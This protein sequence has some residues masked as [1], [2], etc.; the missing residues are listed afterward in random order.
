[1]KFKTDIIA[2]PF[3]AFM[4]SLNFESMDFLGL[5]IDFLMTKITILLLL[6]MAFLIPDKMFSVKRVKYFLFPI[7]LFLILLTAISFLHR[8]G[9]TVSFIDV[10]FILNILIFIIVLNIGFESD[11]IIYKGLLSF[12]LGATIIAVLGILNIQIEE[13][14]EGRYT[15]FGSNA[16][17]LGIRAALSIVIFLF[18]YFKKGFSTLIEKPVLLILCPLMLHSILSTGSRTAFLVLFTGLLILYKPQKGMSV[19]A[20]GVLFYAMM[21]ILVVVWVVFLR[22][23]L[24]VIRLFDTVNSSDLSGRDFLWAK[25]F[26]IIVENPLF[27]VGKTGYAMEIS[28]LLNQNKDGIASP[29]N[30]FVETLA[31]TGIVGLSILLLFLFRVIKAIVRTF[32]KDKNRYPLAFFMPI[33]ATLLS[34]QLF[35][36]KVYWV[37]IAVIIVLS[38]KSLDESKEET[39]ARLDEV[40]TT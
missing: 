31:Y 35:H 29:H 25:V 13:Q 2:Y 40:Q 39:M 8:H 22:E 33:L 24:V 18:L 6:C 11:E 12:A 20:K 5:G 23:S 3:Y 34:G 27:G 9:S 37:L 15:V 7:V 21:G 10:P 19:A 1:M 30:V 28:A 4:F 38:R 36:P 16:N 26:L 14:L 32:R 17:E